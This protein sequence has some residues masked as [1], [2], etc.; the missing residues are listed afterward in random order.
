MIYSEPGFLAVVWFSSSPTPFSPLSFSDFLCA[1]ADIAYW[2][3]RRRGWGRS[4]IR[5]P[6]ESLALYKYVN[7][8]WPIAWEYV[9][10]MITRDR[11]QQ[12][13]CKHRVGRVLS[14]FSS[15]RNW[16]SPYPSPAGECAPPPLFWGE[17]TT[18]SVAREGLGESQFRR[19]PAARMP[20]GHH[21]KL[22][23]RQNLVY[24]KWQKDQLL[25]LENM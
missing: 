11:Q 3:E 23:R 6:R 4:R 14:F 19:V 20:T 2:R 9:T 7:P 24:C 17:G 13:G 5:R 12:Q 15:R 21:N 1:A 22:K 16:D 8:L 10:Y 18:H 25:K